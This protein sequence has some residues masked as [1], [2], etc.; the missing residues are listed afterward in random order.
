MSAEKIDYREFASDLSEYLKDES[1]ETWED[2][3]E[4]YPFESVGNGS[5]V[6]LP[7]G[8]DMVDYESNQRDYL[9]RKPMAPPN[10]PIDFVVGDIYDELAQYMQMDDAVEKLEMLAEM[11]DRYDSAW[12]SESRVRFGPT[13]ENGIEIEAPSL[14]EIANSFNKRGDENMEAD[15][16]EMLLDMASETSLKT[17]LIDRT[18][19]VQGDQIYVLEYQDE[20]PEFYPV[21]E[22]GEAVALE[23]IFNVY[24]MV[25]DGA[26]EDSGQEIFDNIRE[27]FS[28]GQYGEYE[29]FMDNHNERAVLFDTESIEATSM[30]FVQADEWLENYDGEKVTEILKEFQQKF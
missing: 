11:E 22:V 14:A 16:K 19:F 28:Q 4:T 12:T 18:A 7:S 13:P 24:M 3:V 23:D 8:H 15:E 6:F 5:Y 2:L 20:E 17:G 27:M 1:P 26:T 10:T 21:D 9:V 30:G 25:R 29:L